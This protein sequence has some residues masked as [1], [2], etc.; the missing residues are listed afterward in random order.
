LGIFHLSKLKEY[1]KLTKVEGN[2]RKWKWETKSGITK[3]MGNAEA[4]GRRALKVL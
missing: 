3:E 1:L 4:F 2:K